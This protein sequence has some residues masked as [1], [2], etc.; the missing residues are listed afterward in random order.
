MNF[1]RIA[2]P[3]VEPGVINGVLVSRIRTDI[4]LADFETGLRN[5]VSNVENTYWDLYFAY[6]DLDAKKRA[7]DK[8]LE[9]WQDVKAKMDADDEGGEA[10][11]EGQAREQYWRFESEVIDSLNGRLVQATQNENGSSGGTFRSVPGVRVAERRLRLA[12]GL[13]I[14]DT[15]LIRPS[16]EPPEAPIRYDW[17]TVVNQAYQ[18]S[19][20]HI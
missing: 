18:L 20:I 19:L 12:I 9:A 17:N 5:L 6:R 16:E 2:G 15:T 8:A 3:G 10:D 11:K 14:T 4:S 13:P 1:N 7:R